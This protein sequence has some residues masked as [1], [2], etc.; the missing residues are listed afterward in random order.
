MVQP[1]SVTDDLGA[2]NTSLGT[3]KRSG[4]WRT[5]GTAFKCYC[6]LRH[7]R[8]TSGIPLGHLAD[9]GLRR[10][11]ATVHDYLIECPYVGKGSIVAPELALYA[12]ER[13]F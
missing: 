7:S 11:M 13:Q 1:H 10:R 9:S 2:G 12:S 3:A 5:R 4:R 8:P 6:N